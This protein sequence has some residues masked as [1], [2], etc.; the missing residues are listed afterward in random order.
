M[1]DF[2]GITYRYRVGHCSSTDD[3][4]SLATLF[5]SQW[6]C[7]MDFFSHWFF[8]MDFLMAWNFFKWNLYVLR[9]YVSILLTEMKLRGTLTRFTCH[10]IPEYWIYVILITWNQ[11][12]WQKHDIMHLSTVPIERFEHFPSILQRLNGNRIGTGIQYIFSRLKSGAYATIAW[13]AWTHTSCPEAIHVVG[14]TAFG[15]I[16]IKVSDEQ[17]NHIILLILAPLSTSKY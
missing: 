4:T 16:R 12:K 15:S 7:L 13:N 3:I 10:T 1:C 17:Q 9:F 6:F 8:L 14:R 2:H 5:V 11:S